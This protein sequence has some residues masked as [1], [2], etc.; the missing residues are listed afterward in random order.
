M[1]HWRTTL[2]WLLALWLPLQGFAA[3]QMTV[4]EMRHAGEATA[5]EHHD[6]GAMQH[7]H[8]AR[9][10]HMAATAELAADLD[11]HSHFCDGCSLCQH[12]TAATVPTSHAL[13]VAIPAQD[14]IMAPLSRIASF[15]PT[16]PQRPPRLARA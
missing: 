9:H 4:C 6:H 13:P 8:D 5:V 14:L 11:P 15:I 12:C 16:L 2:A 1:K 3:G 10:D 7:A